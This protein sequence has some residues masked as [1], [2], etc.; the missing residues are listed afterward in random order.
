M[1]LNS[2][3]GPVKDL[4]VGTEGN[5][6]DRLLS[7]LPNWYSDG[8][9]IL[10]ALLQGI[11]YTYSFIYSL[12]RYATYQTRISTATGGWL[13]MIA[14]DYYGNSLVRGP[15]QSDDSFRREI[16]MGLFQE[17]ATRKAINN[18]VF[19]LTG[20]TPRIFEPLRVPDTGAYG[21]PNFG[22]GLAGG[23]GSDLLPYQAFIKVK[24]LPRVGIPFIAGYGSSVG[25][26]RTPSQEE[27]FPIGSLVSQVTD[28]QIY[29]ALD[30]TKPVAT[31]LWVNT[32]N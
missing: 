9:P 32:P 13:D 2:K 23:Y 16:L 14:Y 24:A 7:L 27:Y 30:K 25:A 1:A 29:S 15:V 19:Q 4:G 11:A 20:S 21:A 22:Y 26:Y 17:K 5:I 28:A 18:V 3:T 8:T 12:I 6:F 10:S 31:I